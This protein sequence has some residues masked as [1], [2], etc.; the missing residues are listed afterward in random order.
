LGLKVR[1]ETNDVNADSGFHS[2]DYEIDEAV[3]ETWT[4]DPELP[5]ATQDDAG[6]AGL[7]S[8]ETKYW[9]D[10]L[11][12]SYKHIG[13]DVLPQTNVNSEKKW[14][15]LGIKSVTHNPDDL[16]NVYITENVVSLP[17][18]TVQTNK[19]LIPI[20]SKENPTR[21]GLM[22]PADKEKL[23]QLDAGINAETSAAI[24]ASVFSVFGEL[25]YEFN[26]DYIDQ[27]NLTGPQDLFFTIKNGDGDILAGPVPVGRDALTDLFNGDATLAAN[28]LSNQSF[29]D[30]LIPAIQDQIEAN[31]LDAQNDFIA[32]LGASSE[33]V[34]ALIGALG[35]QTPFITSLVNNSEFINALLTPAQG[36]TIPALITALSSNQAFM[37][38]LA[39]SP[40]I[41]A[42]AQNPDFIA[43]LKNTD[44]LRELGSEAANGGPGSGGGNGLG[45]LPG[46]LATNNTFADM[47]GSSTDLQKALVNDPEFINHLKNKINNGVD[48]T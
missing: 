14:L 34:D 4:G 24:T 19:L 12:E 7:V 9:L 20:V 2:K 31:L 42:L 11:I 29:I 33:I 8:G 41:T 28:L 36:E 38:A 21:P 25:Q 40:F 3:A 46:E 48:W 26:L 18:G 32:Q 22:T 5:G 10:K 6:T 44:L 15:S 13:R 35:T 39:A 1:V 23:D 37:N 47:L 17:N 27:Q 30:G 16:N 45:T 43:A